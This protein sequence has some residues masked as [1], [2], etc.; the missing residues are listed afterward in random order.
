MEI[1][2]T[3]IDNEEWGGTDS[4]YI[5]VR[6]N[7]PTCYTPPGD[8]IHA[9]YD[10]DSVYVGFPNYFL[11]GVFFD[12]S[13]IGKVTGPDSLYCG[14]VPIDSTAEAR[15]NITNDSLAQYRQIKVVSVNQPFSI[16][17]TIEMMYPCFEYPTLPNCY[18]HPTKSGHYV[19]TAK[20]LDSLT[21]D[22]ISVVLIGDAYDARVSETP[23]PQVTLFPN[24]CDK[25]LQIDIP[26]EE[27][28]QIKIY[29][30]FGDCIFASRL[31]SGEA[32]IDCSQMPAGV[33]FVS[34]D[35]MT[36]RQKLII[37]H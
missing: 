7:T 36:S 20:L 26:S 30:L 29:N 14:S 34:I 23:A 3:Q 15:I 11:Q 27:V 8:G 13:V 9:Y 32:A 2:V 18:F 28:S 33:Y 25:E 1:R 6:S 12:P 24:P 10:S 5:V 31:Q 4:L 21:G 22:T 35:G 37:T 19:D 17:D 16:D